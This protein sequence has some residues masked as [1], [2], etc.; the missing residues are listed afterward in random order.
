MASTKD[1]RFQ[2]FSFLML[3]VILLYTAVLAVFLCVR[4]REI[5][6][7]H[8]DQPAN[9]RHIDDQARFSFDWT[10]SV[11]DV[12][13]CWMGGD[14]MRFVLLVTRILST[15]GFVFG[16]LIYYGIYYPHVFVYFDGWT[17]IL[18]TIY[19]LIAT[20]L[21][22]LKVEVIRSRS[23]MDLRLNPYYA[24]VDWTYY[25]RLFAVGAHILFEICCASNFL[26]TFGVLAK[27]T[28]DSDNMVAATS[29]SICLL[30]LDLGLNNLKFRFDQ[31]P[32]TMAWMVFYFLCIWPAVFSGSIHNWPYP[33]MAVNTTA[34]F[35]NYT[36]MFAALFVSYLCWYFFFRV[37]RLILV[38]LE[39]KG[40]LIPI[41]LENPYAISE[42]RQSQLEMDG[43]VRSNR[44][45]RSTGSERSTGSA[46]SRSS[47]KSVVRNP[48]TVNSFLF[49]GDMNDV[50]TLVLDQPEY[51]A[52]SYAQFNAYNPNQP[53]PGMEPAAMM[54]PPPP[55]AF[56]PMDPQQQ[57]LLHQQQMLYLQQQVPMP[58][59]PPP[60]GYPNQMNGAND[61]DPATQQ[62]QQELF[63]QQQM[64][65]QQYQ[66]YVQQQQMMMQ[67]PAYQQQVQMQQVMAMYP[68]LQ[69]PAYLQEQQQ[70][71]YLLSLMHNPDTSSNL[72]GNGNNFPQQQ[73]QVPVPPSPGMHP[74]YNNMM[75]PPMPP[76][77]MPP[78]HYQQQYQQQF[79][80]QQQHPPLIMDDTAGMMMTPPPGYPQLHQQQQQQ[81]SPQAQQQPTYDFFGY[82]HSNNSSGTGF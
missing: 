65:M 54:P 5:K 78:P 49:T 57:E 40:I 50:D 7:R 55:P 72:G 60:P 20:F 47:T 70:E 59:I 30:F 63:M 13:E 16:G 48:V 24:I 14:V 2:Y 23:S 61:M 67:D 53:L 66:A 68:A 8:L 41:T 18:T 19:F 21:S 4:R 37:K 79:Q 76:G 69:D 64:Q 42:R 27:L 12:T 33:A 1:P 52:N 38:F 44:S 56:Y 75:M 35:K 28:P 3:Y 34:C 15:I 36:Y 77:V 29:L 51:N 31:F 62:Q 26:C 74:G 80:M 32:A 22:V 73:Q 11:E 58:M 82:Q 71:L 45:H 25:P 81:I 17:L 43:S 39:Y 9:F 46:K 6:I 10:T